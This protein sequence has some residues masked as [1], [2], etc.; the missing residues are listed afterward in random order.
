M[1]KRNFA[2]LLYFYRAV[3]IILLCLW[4]RNWVFLRRRWDILKQRL[5]QQKWIFLPRCW[6]IF[7]RCFCRQKWV[8]LPSCQDFCCC[9]CGNEVGYF[10]S[11]VGT[12]SSSVCG[13]NLDICNETS[14]H[15]PADGFFT[16]GHSDIFQLRLWQQ[17]K[18]NSHKTS[19]HFR[20]CL[21]HQVCFFFFLGHQDNLRSTLSR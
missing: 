5:W 2:F 16:S 6:D 17:N 12:F 10:Y 7:K 8:F 1:T 9:V 11:D 15:F 4:Q 13:D 14:G 19:E 20:L 21:Q 3:R 18:N